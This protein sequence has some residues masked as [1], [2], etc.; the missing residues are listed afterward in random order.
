MYIV[1]HF[2]GR[3]SKFP[4]WTSRRFHARSSTRIGVLRR[5]LTTW[6]PMGT[7]ARTIQRTSG[8][9]SSD[10]TDGASRS[11]HLPSQNRRAGRAAHRRIGIMGNRYPQRSSRTGTPLKVLH[12]GGRTVA[13]DE[14]RS[15]IERPTYRVTALVP[16][17]YRSPQGFPPANGAL[18]TKPTLVHRRVRVTTALS[19]SP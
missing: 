11:R 4:V 12:S 14:T 1:W 18:K 15:G 6:M 19:P 8:T 7:E 9:P 17:G 10:S 16:Q 13:C 3:S 2:S 5:H